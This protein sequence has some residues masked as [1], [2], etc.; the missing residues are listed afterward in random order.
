MVNPI[1]MQPR[2]IRRYVT[3]VNEVAI[4]LVDNMAY[5][6][7]LNKNGEMPDDFLDELYKFALE[8]VMLVAVDRRLG[9]VF[10]NQTQCNVLKRS[11]MVRR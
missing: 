7:G 4:E 1:L 8:S 10:T 6:A 2:V 3:S 5:F 11:L 9:I